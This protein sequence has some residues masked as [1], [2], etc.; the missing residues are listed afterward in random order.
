VFTDGWA[1]RQRILS[2]ALHGINRIFY[3]RDLLDGTMKRLLDAFAWDAERLVIRSGGRELSAVYVLAGTGAP[4]FLIC[5]GIG[6]R[7]EYWSGV[8][9]MLK[10]MGISSLVFNYSGYGASSGKVSVA[11]CEEDAVAA[12]G[13][14]AGRGH[15]GSIFLLGFSMGSGVVLAV[16]PQLDVDGVILCEGYATLREAAVAIGFPRWSTCMMPDVWQ[17]INQVAK[18]QAPVLVVHSDEDR[19]FPLTMAERVCKACG[20]NGE[21]IMV[22]GLSHDAPVYAPTKAY[23]QPV[24]EW[25]KRHSRQATIDGSSVSQS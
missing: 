6:E 19:L 9:Q 4:A 10:T 24:V 22:P 7:V 1:V 5:H 15:C 25:A 12:Y 11:H 8:Q 16:A 23:W 21:L 2:A 20:E 3:R 14:L 18:L 13:K 17:N